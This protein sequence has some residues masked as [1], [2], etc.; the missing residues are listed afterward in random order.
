[1]KR[2]LYLTMV[3]LVALLILVP[4]AMA[5]EMEAEVKQEMTVEK[6]LPKSGGVGPAPLVLPAAALLIGAGVLG[7]AVLRRR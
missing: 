2:V 4:S 7:Y 5:Q 1:V 6:D 3:A